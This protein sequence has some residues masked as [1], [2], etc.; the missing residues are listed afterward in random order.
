LQ[1]AGWD[2]A[3]VGRVATGMLL[4]R[5]RNGGSPEACSVLMSTEII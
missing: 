5:I 1:V 2:Q 3:E 4:D